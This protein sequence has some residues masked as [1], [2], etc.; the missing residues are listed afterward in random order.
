MS[1]D[2]LETIRQGVSEHDKLPEWQACVDLLASTLLDQSPQQ[3]ERLLADGTR[4]TAW[5]RAGTLAR[6]Y[7]SP[8]TA[9]VD[10]L[11]LAE[12]LEW[13]QS[14]SPREIAPNG[15]HRIGQ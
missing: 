12:S 13:L 4:F 5:A 6:K 11:A 15:R 7:I 9:A 8:E 10:P 3:A 1:D 14:G 2:L